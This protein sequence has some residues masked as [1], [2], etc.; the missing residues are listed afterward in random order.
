[1]YL[2]GFVLLA[3]VESC[4]WL[5]LSLAQPPHTSHN[6][7]LKYTEHKTNKKHTASKRDKEES[8][9]NTMLEEIQALHFIGLLDAQNILSAD[10]G[11]S[12]QTEG[13]LFGD[14]LINGSVSVTPLSVIEVSLVLCPVSLWLVSLNVQSACALNTLFFY[15]KLLHPDNT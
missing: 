3:S 7:F 15:I 13:H 2:I 1:V 5:W 14:H 12:G 6:T 4:M 11:I 8:K 9:I 10:T